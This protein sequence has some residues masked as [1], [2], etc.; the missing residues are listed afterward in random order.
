[1]QSV[2][3]L[4][5]RWVVLGMVAGWAVRGP[6]LAVTGVGESEQAATRRRLTTP[7][8]RRRSTARTGRK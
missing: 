7:R 1:M 6:V 8:V 2:P 4:I 3:L 5:L